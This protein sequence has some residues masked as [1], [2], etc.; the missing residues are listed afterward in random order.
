VA[1]DGI[2]VLL[3]Q[4]P[5]LKARPKIA[6]AS[7]SLPDDRDPNARILGFMEKRELYPKTPSRE[8]ATAGSGPEP[9]RRAPG[10]GW[11]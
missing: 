1:G 2:A 7:V 5:A 4:L 8:G 3:P 6:R 11:R 9:S 10:S